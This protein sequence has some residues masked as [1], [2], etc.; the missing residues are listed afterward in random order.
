MFGTRALGRMH[1]ATERPV[2]AHWSL[3]QHCLEIAQFFEAPLVRLFAFWR[4]GT[5]TPERETASSRCWSAPCPM[6][7]APG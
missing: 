3:L 1:A 5:L 4:A 6:P 7:S 2:E